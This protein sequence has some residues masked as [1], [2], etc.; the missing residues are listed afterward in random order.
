VTEPP[1]I[2]TAFAFCVAIVPSVR[3]VLTND[4]SVLSGTSAV[5]V[6][7]TPVRVS[8]GARV[9]VPSGYEPCRAIYDVASMGASY[10]S[11]I[12]LPSVSSR[13]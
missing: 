7:T 5:C 13:N 1:V 9:R 8:V 11:K 4:A 2:A 10:V 6:V 12:G 3:Y